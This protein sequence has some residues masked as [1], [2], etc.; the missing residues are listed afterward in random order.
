V[1]GLGL[2]RDG[3]INLFEPCRNRRIVALIGA[4]YRPLRTQAP[5]FQVS[6]HRAQRHCDGELALNQ[7]RHRRARPQVKRQLQLIGHLA[8]YQLVDARGLLIVERAFARAPTSALGFERP[9]STQLVQR[10]PFVHRAKTRIKQIR[11][12]DL[13]HPIAH[14][15][16][17]LPSQHVLRSRFELPR[18]IS[19]VHANNNVSRTIWCTDQ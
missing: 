2:A 6:P 11:R 10:N 19:F 4:S 13:L 5:G 9:Q 18:I 15:I 14:R 12:L 1:L 17:Y 8:Q 3:R 16:H 7:L